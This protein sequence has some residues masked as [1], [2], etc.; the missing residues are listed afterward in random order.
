MQSSDVLAGPPL[1]PVVS[2]TVPLLWPPDA[3]PAVAETT[4][5][6][7]CAIRFTSLLKME[8]AVESAIEVVITSP[9]NNVQL[10]EYSLNG[11]D[12]TTYTF[13][14]RTGRVESAG[15]GAR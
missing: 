3:D 14:V 2:V 12:E 13:L 9:S 6:V 15:W 7:G 1:S 5:A 10:T 4:G 8:L 11:Y